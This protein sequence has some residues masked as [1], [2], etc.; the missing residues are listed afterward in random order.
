MEKLINL[1]IYQV[2]SCITFHT[3]RSKHDTLT[4]ATFYLTSTADMA[5]ATVML[6]TPVC[7]IETIY[8]RTNT[9][10]FSTQTDQIQTAFSE[11]TD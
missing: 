2:I 8:H 3:H 1:Q 9:D 4:T 11:N 6:T 7:S 10:N 5:T